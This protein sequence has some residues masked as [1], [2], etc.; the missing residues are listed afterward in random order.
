MNREVSCVSWPFRIHD[1]SILGDITTN[2]RELKFAVIRNP[3]RIRVKAPLDKKWQRWNPKALWLL[4]VGAGRTVNTIHRQTMKSIGMNSLLC[5]C[6]ASPKSIRISLNLNL[7]KIKLKW[8]KLTVLESV[9]YKEMCFWKSYTWIN[10][11]RFLDFKSLEDIGRLYVF[12]R[13]YLNRLQT[14]PRT[15][16]FFLIKK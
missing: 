14:Y 13:V 8:I 3:I 11:D 9:Q 15:S 12:E 1:K 2:D 10:K 5:I 16:S 7:W 6:R 4:F